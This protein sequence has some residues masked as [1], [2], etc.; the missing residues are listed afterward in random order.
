[1]ANRLLLNGADWQCL[2]D[3]GPV[4]AMKL[5]VYSDPDAQLSNAVRACVPGSPYHDL[6]VAGEI[7]NIYV[8]TNS[9]LCEWVANRHW[10][11]R[12]VFRT[13]PQ[14]SDRRVALVLNGIDCEAQVFLNGKELG[15]HNSQ[16]TPAR[17]DVT[18]L[19]HDGQPNVLL[20]CI[21]R[22]PDEESQ[23]GHTSRVR[24][25]K[26]RMAY[27]WDF[28]AR[29]VGIG[30]WDDVFL[31][32]TGPARLE[33]VWVRTGLADTWD[34]GSVAV[35]V[36]FDGPADRI[37]ATLH[38]PQGRAIARQEQP[39]P[40]EVTEI[41]FD[42]PSPE[43]WWPNGMGNQPLYRVEVEVIRNGETSDSR[44]I[45]TAF[46]SVSQT[47]TDGAPAG[48]RPYAL[49]VN[50]QR[51]RI[52][53]WNWTPPD[54]QYGLPMEDRYRRLIALARQANVNLLRVWGGGIIEKDLFYS[55]CD[56]AGILVWQEFI[57]SSSGLCN[58]PSRQEAYLDLL[59]RE[60][61]PAIRKRRNHPSLAIWC[62]GNELQGPGDIP[63]DESH[64]AIAVLRDCV[65]DS[66]PDRLFVPTSALG[67]YEF[68]TLEKVKQS[69]ADLHDVHGPWD[70]QGPV[71]TY[72]LYNASPA[73][74]HS[75]FGTPGGAHPENYLLFMPH[76]YCWPP[77]PLQRDW[78]N[79]GEWWTRTSVRDVP[80]LFGPIGPP[81]DYRRFLLTA[82]W[83]QFEGLRYAIES[84][85][86]RGN[87]SAGTIPWQFNVP[88]PNA[89]CTN[90]VDWFTQPKAGY[91]AVRAAYR[92][93][94]ASLR[95]PGI[96]CRAGE[97]FAVEV[98]L[99]ATRASHQP[100]TLEVGAFEVTGIP[101]SW[102]ATQTYEIPVPG[103]MDRRVATLPVE[104]PADWD[105]LF[106]IELRLRTENGEWQNPYCFSTT[107]PPLAPMWGA[108]KTALAVRET[109]R[110]LSRQLTITN[111]G[112]VPAWWV[113]A[114]EPRPDQTMPLH[115]NANL[116]AALFSDGYVVLL[117][118]E[119]WSITVTSWAPDLSGRPWQVSAWNTEPVSG[120][121]A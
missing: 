99:H 53:G 4:Y 23:F 63:L 118:G 8:G 76:P 35:T 121:F 90:S 29:V 83:I 16:F 50:G 88:W 97:S 27:G 24:S 33:D 102:F 78:N 67:P 98:W 6:A 55:L 61:P 114:W 7:P 106:C 110:K 2:H 32:T 109:C 40:E 3:L 108:P 85:R 45:F 79:H 47:M 51:M 17:F 57:L 56:E 30:I 86:R 87:R 70:Y 36:E 44:S 48:A 103:P 82:Q 28:C 52:F 77:D 75:E 54:V 92:P 11:F 1:M 18:G 5:P 95:H 26:T 10:T 89:A 81:E 49:V 80:P 46:R 21:R 73:L 104:V 68:L 96:A 111:T 60:A 62:G 58:E 71:T 113:R 9:R 37:V 69:P 107:D 38:D 59:R 13:P 119:S 100:L 20:V 94:H 74:L 101:L 22:A 39:T 15:H 93:L 42:L 117:P 91:E 41:A 14:G 105:G 34:R 112:P 120:K 116:P 84:N 12:K 72:E 66:D 43:L 25:F 31:E 115:P 19:L 64:P 65:A